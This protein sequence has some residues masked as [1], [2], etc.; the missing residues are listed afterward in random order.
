MKLFWEASGL[1]AEVDKQQPAE[2]VATKQCTSASVEQGMCSPLNKVCAV[3]EFSC[4]S[5]SLQY[6]NE[7]SSIDGT[8]C[9]N[10]C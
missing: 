4:H 10:S 3:E 9:C 2:R 1:L 8:V 7:M 6:E 5:I